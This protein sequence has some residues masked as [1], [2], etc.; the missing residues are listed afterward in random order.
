M[1]LAHKPL[2]QSGQKPRNDLNASVV[3][4]DCASQTRKVSSGINARLIKANRMDSDLAQA[5]LSTVCRYV[6]KECRDD[7]LLQLRRQRRAANQRA[8]VARR[9]NEELQLEVAFLRVL[10][11]CLLKQV[12][13]LHKEVGGC[14]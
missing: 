3:I 6:Q 12:R 1:Q 8:L 9:K 2:Q 13:K 14:P 10:N 5:A 11:M 4:V 7:V